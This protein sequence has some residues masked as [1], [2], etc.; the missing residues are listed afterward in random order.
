VAGR[1]DQIRTE[2]NQT[3]EE[4]GRK[5]QDLETKVETS[6]HEAKERVEDT[7]ERVK[8]AARELSPV[9]QIRQRPLIA[10][11]GALAGGFLV[12]RWAGARR[13]A[14]VAR[15]AFREVAPRTGPSWFGQLGRQ[16]EP[17]LK[18]IKGALVGSAVKYAMERARAKKP[19]LA[20]EI[21]KLEQSLI[22]R[23]ARA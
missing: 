12:A 19:E 17:E 23:F 3:T 22:S 7:V 1:K 18:V 14:P 15:H 13:L 21:S 9:H 5:V 2:M 8:T 11:G 10:V 4:L 16:F 20:E 6:Y